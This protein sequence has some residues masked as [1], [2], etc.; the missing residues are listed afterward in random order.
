MRSPRN[1][2]FW[3]G[4]AFASGGSAGYDHKKMAITARGAWECV[5]RHF[6]EIGVDI[7]QQD[8][9]VA[10][11]GDMAGDVFGNGML[12]SPHIRLVAAFNHQHIFIDP[13]PDAARSFKERERMFRLPRSSWED[14]SKSAISKGGGVYS[15]SAKSLSLSRE[16]QTL[17]ELPAQATPNEVVKA[18]LKSHVD[19]LWN[20]GIGTYVKASSESH[21]DVGDRSND[22][23]RIDA[24]QLNCKVIGEGGNLGFSQLGRIEFARRGGRLNTDFI[25]NSAGVNCSDVEVNLK[26]LLNGAV[27]AREITRAARDRLLVQMTDEV[28]AL[29]LRNN[30]LQGQA[31]STSEFQA[32]ERLSESVAVIRALERSGDLN[33]ALEFLPSEEEIAERRKGGEGLTRPE[34]AIVLSYGKIWLYKALIHS[35]VPEDPYLSGEL[36]RYFPAPVRQRFAVRLKRH[37]LR[38]EIIATAITNSLINR[39]G[40]VFPVRAQDDTGADPAAIARAYTIAREVFA[41]R[42]IWAQIEDLDNRIPAAVQYTAMFQ[43]SRL[44]RHTSYWMLENLREHLDIER[45]VRRYAA[46]VSELWRELNSVLSSTARA[47]LTAQRS[48]LI[49]QHVPEQLATRIAS[50]DT[51]HSALDLVEA[52]MAARVKIGYAAKAYF[53]IGERIGLTW[54]KEQIE[55]LAVEGKWQAAA[56]RTVRDDLYALHRK[57]TG[58]VLKCKGRDAEG[59]VGQWMQRKAGSV[60]SLKRIVVDLR[61]GSPPDF[62]TLSVALQAVRRLVQE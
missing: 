35:N 28:A 42:D 21:S 37:R 57:I 25:D 14:Y 1:T 59:R 34:L 56:R 16:A 46:P 51:L 50:L 26:I 20:G 43:T 62:A 12:Q 22:A 5:K 44:L 58:A 49:E 23:V 9:S 19:L 24:E 10:G 53:D 61:T 55:S 52:A 2:A 18:I 3:L 54:I 15:R 27:R 38:R 33:R 8:F 30:Y 13:D 32:K 48:Q 6:R 47:R 41:V 11:I 4:D 36:I 7:Q 39:M 31:I 17:L 45:A 40:P 60:D 29:V